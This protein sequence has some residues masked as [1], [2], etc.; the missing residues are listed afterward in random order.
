MLEG[1]SQGS[2]GNRKRQA[3]VKPVLPPGGLALVDG[4]VEVGDGRGDGRRPGAALAAAALGRHLQQPDGLLGRRR[5]GPQRVVLG[6]VAH[7][8]VGRVLAGARHVA[9]LRSAAVR[10]AAAGG[11]T[12]ARGGG[13]GA[14]PG[15]ATQRRRTG[16]GA[17]GRAKLT[18]HCPRTGRGARGPQGRA[19]AG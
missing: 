13:A 8:V 16:E 11:V 19:G 14:V 4:R 2:C 1:R 6:D 18:S 10:G 5:H 12:A 15:D 7:L 9:W 3:A 17:V